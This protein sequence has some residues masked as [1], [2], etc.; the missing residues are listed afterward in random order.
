MLPSSVL[1]HCCRGTGEPHGRGPRQDHRRRRSP[2]ARQATPGS[3]TSR[4]VRRRRLPLPGPSPWPFPWPFPS[5]WLCHTPGLA[6]PAA[7]EVQRAAGRQALAFASAQ[8][9]AE[10]EAAAQAADPLIRKLVGWLRLQSRS[11]AASAEEIVRFVL[12]GLARPGGARAGRGGAG[13]CGRQFPGRELFR[14]TPAPPRAGRLQ[15]LADALARAG[16]PA[17]G[18][19]GHRLAGRPHDPAAKMRL[20]RAQCRQPDAGGALAPVRPAGPGTG[21][22]PGGWWAIRPAPSGPRHRP[23]RLCRRPAVGCP[24]A[25][26]HRRRRRR[27]D[28]GAGRWLRRREPAAP[29]PP[30]PGRPT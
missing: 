1:A 21:S 26:R 4:P 6:Q 11:A 15:R 23:P 9:W 22:R 16:R 10:A 30:P 2:S 12:A 17:G 18:S 13:R 19:A 7:A 25:G 14:R 3:A 8:R 24:D 29:R 28:P 20:P 5:P 27:A